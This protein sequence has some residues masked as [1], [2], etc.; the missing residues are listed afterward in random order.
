MNNT[1]SVQHKNPG[2]NNTE[3]MTQKNRS[4]ETSHNR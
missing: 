3:R 4:V 1:L 2:L